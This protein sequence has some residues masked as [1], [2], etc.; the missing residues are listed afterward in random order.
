MP[1]YFKDQK[2]VLAFYHRPQGISL[3]GIDE[4]CSDKRTGKSLVIAARGARKNANTEIGDDDSA[5]ADHMRR[6]FNIFHN[7]VEYGDGAVAKKAQLEDPDAYA[8]VMTW[9]GGHTTR[10][11]L[12]LAY[13]DGEPLP[14]CPNGDLVAVRR[15]GA[16]L[17]SE[18][19]LS[20]FAD[21]EANPACSFRRL[22]GLP[23]STDE[24]VD[25]KYARLVD[26]DLN[27]YC[28][29]WAFDFSMTDNFYELCDVYEEECG[30]E[31]PFWETHER[32]VHKINQE[33]LTQMHRWL[34]VPYELR[35]ILSP[36]QDRKWRE[37]LIPQII[38]THLD[39]I[40]IKLF[41][42]QL[43][44]L[45]ADI[46]KDR[47]YEQRLGAAWDNDVREYLSDD[48]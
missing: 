5:E 23:L 9:A 28:V 21:A 14:D 19:L 39:F 4:L 33:A 45:G 26:V 22:D 18:F 20:R 44:D 16:E 1:K 24:A 37:D 36:E 46:D 41:G 10:R 38:Q 15:G 31:V 40:G 29:D 13:D 48:D 34:A 42:Q 47:E 43:D 3:E 32:A 2:L 6:L 35:R 8:A 7:D 12:V 25:L 11:L 27:L 30:D 17:I